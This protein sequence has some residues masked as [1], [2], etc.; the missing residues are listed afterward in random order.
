[1]VKLQEKPVTLSLNTPLFSDKRVIL[2]NISWL[3]FKGILQ[4][5]GEDR[6]YRIAYNLGV[7]EL[8]MPL[9]EHEVPK[10]LLESFIEAIADEL[11]IELMSLGA[12]KLP[13]EDL[14]KFIEPDSCFYIQNESL[15]RDKKITLPE[16]PP[17]DLVIESDYTHSS[18]DKLQI[19]ASL[20]VPEIW[21]YSKQNLFQIYQLTDSGYKLS[22]KSL[23]FPLINISEISDLLSQI[24]KIGQRKIV[25]LFKAK[26][27][28]LTINNDQ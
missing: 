25:K 22:E 21:R 1:M 27:Q 15:V 7:L 24:G 23:V 26:I 28:Q 9:Q 12:L 2:Y 6:I 10:R 20:G 14:N 11:D 5:V 18:L 16:C 8:R 3:T 4:D 13:R 17:P 19:Y